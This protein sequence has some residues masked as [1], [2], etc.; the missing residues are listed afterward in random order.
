M[1]FK[2]NVFAGK[3]ERV[4]SNQLPY[5]IVVTQRQVFS[6]KYP[7][8]SLTSLSCIVDYRQLPY[9]IRNPTASFSFKYHCNLSHQS[10]LHSATPHTTYKPCIIQVS[11]LSARRASNPFAR[12]AETI[13]VDA[14]GSTTT[15]VGRDNTTNHDA[16]GST[17]TNVGRDNIT[18]HVPAVVGPHPVVHYC[19]LV[20]SFAAFC[21]ALYLVLIDR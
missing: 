21:L 3:R 7:V 13:E 5:V 19:T 18:I 14:R 2:P 4:T 1:T 12:P 10:L 20:C 16:R 9:V 6:F 15:N 17:T 11:R 8:T